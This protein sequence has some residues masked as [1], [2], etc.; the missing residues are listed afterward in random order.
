LSRARRIYP[1]AKCTFRRKSC[2]KCAGKNL[3]KEDFIKLAREK[4]GD[5]YDYSKVEYINQ[6]TKVCIICPEHGEFYVKPY[7]HIHVKSGCKKCKIH[8]GAY[9]ETTEQFIE[10]AKKVHGDKYDYSK[11]VY[12]GSNNDVCIICTCL[13]VYF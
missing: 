9:K 6:T 13:V 5:K 12:L 3:T 4:Y 1:R 11:T 10:K 2:P 7:Y 8:E